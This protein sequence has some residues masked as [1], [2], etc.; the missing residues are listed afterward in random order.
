M[1]PG[2]ALG[3]RHVNRPE[4]RGACGDPLEESDAGV[5]KVRRPLRLVPGR[6]FTGAIT[7]MVVR[8]SMSDHACDSKRDPYAADLIAL[9]PTHACCQGRSINKTLD[10]SIQRL[11][12]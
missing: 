11:T 3:L 9:A 10:S 2:N 1:L 8:S 6:R 12:Q 4:T 7:S 5:P